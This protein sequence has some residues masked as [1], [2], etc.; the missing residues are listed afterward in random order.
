MP[1]TEIRRFAEHGRAR[2][3]EKGRFEVLEI[4][5]LTIGR[6]TYE[7]G[8]KWSEHVGAASGASL[9]EVEHVG[10]VVSGRAAVSFPDGERYELCPG[11]VFYIPPGH[12]SWVIG[13]E[14]Y[15]SLHFLGA[16]SY[17]RSPHDG[18]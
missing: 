3:F 6:A 1:S 18:G 17:A 16:D 9:C 12:D 5:G 10:M 8:W 13:A 7:A 2:E 15:V 14:S 4:G 11:D